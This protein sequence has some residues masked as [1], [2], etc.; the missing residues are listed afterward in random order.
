MGSWNEFANYRPQQHCTSGAIKPL[1]DLSSTRAYLSTSLQEEQQRG[2][3]VS[4]KIEPI[5]AFSTYIAL[6]SQK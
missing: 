1:M 5:A 3:V 6:A 4:N 2:L